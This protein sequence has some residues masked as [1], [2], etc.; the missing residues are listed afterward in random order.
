MDLMKN[1]NELVDY[2]EMHKNQ[3]LLEKDLTKVANLPYYQLNAIFTAIT[4]IGIK[5]YIRLRRITEATKILINSNKKIIDIAFDYG[6]SNPE[7]FTKAFKA[8]HGISPSKARTGL[9]SLKYIPKFEFTIS[10]KG[11]RPLQYRFI[12]NE[13]IHFIGKSY[14]FK[15]NYRDLNFEKK[16][17]NDFVDEGY[18]D[19]IRGLSL[20]N[21]IAGVLYKIDS[22]NLEYSYLIGIRTAEEVKVSGYEN[23][24]ITNTN[25]VCFDRKGVLPKNIDEFKKQIFL[26]WIL[27]NNFELEEKYEIEQYSVNNDWPDKNVFSY[28][29]S[30]SSSK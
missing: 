29:I 8:I 25:F 27:N 24:T 21:T 12:Y 15:G 6:Y 19:R 17:W 20:N 3:E 14:D 16:L 13:T 22:E 11:K 18:Y 7:A 5:E 9:Y 4:D 23:L 2:I 28:L 10:L 30:F 26:D 1:L